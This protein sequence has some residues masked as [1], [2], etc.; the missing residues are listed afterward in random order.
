MEI[1]KVQ[2]PIITSETI[3][4]ALIYNES[5]SIQFQIP[6]TKKLIKKMQG[7]FKQFFFIDTE[8][9]ITGKAPWQSW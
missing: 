6:V 8:N 5:R 3:K 7:E 4:L 9:N 2:I 1:V